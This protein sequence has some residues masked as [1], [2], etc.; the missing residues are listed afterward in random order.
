MTTQYLTEDPVASP[1]PIRE[2]K[3]H[4][5]PSVR[6]R[7]AGFLATVQLILLLAHSFVYQT[8]VSFRGDPDPPGTT[9]IQAALLLLSFAFV[10]ASLLTFRY[11]NSLVRLLY[12]IA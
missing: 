6:G 12:R 10:G 5:T 1:A 7:I 4:R 8:W 11:S 2:M 3:S 9:V